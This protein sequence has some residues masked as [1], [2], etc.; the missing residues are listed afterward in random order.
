MPYALV[1]FDLDGTLADSLPWFRRNV[2]D[3]ADKFGFRR[4]AEEDVDGLRRA[5][6]REILERL[7]VPHW[8]LPMIASHLRRL[9]AQHLHDI[10]LF[11]GTAEVLR[12]LKD[13]GLS[14]ALVSSD[15]ERNA[16]RQLGTANAGLIS[17]FA[18][19]ASLFGKAAKFR[20]VLKRTR[21]L[22]E[23]AIAIGD[24]V[25]DIDAARAAGIACGAV[26]WGYAATETLRA[27]RPDLVFEH[28]EDIVRSLL[29]RPTH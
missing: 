7:N 16:R 22:P 25:R 15:T 8:K 20:R 14:L 26:T 12:T 2:N 11:P 10:P 23:R 24:E 29:A 28:M 9:K 17:E 1:I 6:T 18:C 13:A 5:G 4:I 21:I 3:V 19:G 27:H